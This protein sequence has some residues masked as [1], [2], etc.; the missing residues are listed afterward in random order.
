VCILRI[1]GK[2]TPMERAFGIDISPRSHTGYTY[3]NKH[4]FVMVGVSD[5]NFMLTGD[6]VYSGIGYE[7]LLE[8]AQKAPVTI[9]YHYMRSSWSVD[10]Q[11]DVFLAAIEGFDVDAYCL[12]F[13]QTNNIK[14]KEFATK[15]KTMLYEMDSLAPSILYSGRYL[16]QDW[17]FYYDEYFPRENEIWIAQ[18][19]YY[20]WNEWY[21]D[22]TTNLNKVPVLPAGCDWRLWQYSA[23]GNN[24]ASENG[25]VGGK[26]V[27][28]NVYNGTIQEMKEW[29]Q[30]GV[31]E[32]PTPIPGCTDEEKAL[33]RQNSI[34]ECI[35][36]L[37]EL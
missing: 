26:S 21:A 32:P 15:T 19:P 10:T 33:I 16:I 4:D 11:L 37:K 35:N 5:G 13:E 31:V 6:N 8:E 1:L 9:A 24:K 2:E 30:V 23:D 20:G 3:Q 14:S 28:L 22:M 25:L 18:Y 29:A 12:D 7:R 17:L 36:A 34:Q 27:D